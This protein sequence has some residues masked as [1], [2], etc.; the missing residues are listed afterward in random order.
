M[1]WSRTLIAGVVGGV[2]ASVLNFVFHGLILAGTYESRP[3]VFNQEGG[4][5]VWFL[6]AGIIVVTVAAAGFSKSRSSW[7][8]GF[9]GGVPFG[10]MVGGVI[11]FTSF[12]WPL[13]IA[14]FPYYL[15]WCWLGVDLITYGI[16][17]GVLG[18][19]IKAD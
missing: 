10:L 1:N 11:G 19:L 8:P 12:Y 6:V 16:V 18:L 13:V 17:G 3:E 9:A 7:A 5:E 15:A 2:L 4:G 14:D